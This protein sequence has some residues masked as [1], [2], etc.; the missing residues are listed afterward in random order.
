MSGPE[1]GGLALELLNAPDIELVPTVGLAGGEPADV[2]LHEP[3]ERLVNVRPGVQT[4]SLLD[5]RQKDARHLLYIA[6]LLEDKLGHPIEAFAYPFGTADD[7][8]AV[9][10]RLVQD[11]GFRYAVSNRYG[12]VR[13]G[14]DR[15]TLR[16]IWIDS[17]DS[18]ELLKA[19]VQGHLDALAVL[20]TS[21]GVRTRRL[22]NQLLRT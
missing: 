12:P 11:A 18:L 15:W 22:L 3:S 9:T 14:A 16:R 10:V 1:R 7:Y 8:D 17:T 4:V 2:Q 6:R 5:P 13:P 21:V 20:D 19:K